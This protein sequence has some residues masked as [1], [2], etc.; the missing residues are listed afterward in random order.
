MGELVKSFGIIN[1]SVTPKDASLS[2]QNG[3][4]S[5]DEK[6]MTSYGTYS[7][8]MTRNDYVPGRIEFAIDR[9][10][11]Y[12][13]D[14]LSL[15]PIPRYT[16]VGTGIDHI[17]NISDSTWTAHTE[18]GMILLDTTLSGGVLISS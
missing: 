11:P 13:I 16:R 12:Y 7:L 5:N 9:E 18:S 10:T 15:L 6:R 4:Y 2:L 1:I 17:A 3:A 14:T 8:L